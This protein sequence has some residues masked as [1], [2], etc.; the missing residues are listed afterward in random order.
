MLMTSRQLWRRVLERQMRNRYL[1]PHSIPTQN[2]SVEELVHHASRIYRLD[3]Q[4]EECFVLWTTDFPSPT[5]FI[6][7]SY[8]QHL[9]GG[10]WI[11]A[12]QVV[13]SRAHLL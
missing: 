3:Q 5:A 4:F 7:E 9:P 11:I 13:N 8:V 10:R 6:A 1:A 2:L 12:C